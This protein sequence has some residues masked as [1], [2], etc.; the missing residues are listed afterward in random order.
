[1]T[2]SQYDSCVS[3]AYLLS[4]SLSLS[5]SLIGI[6]AVCLQLLGSLDRA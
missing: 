4:L 3:Y 2:F 1:M 6:V 5:L